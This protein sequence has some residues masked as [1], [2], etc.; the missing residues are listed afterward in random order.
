MVPVTAPAEG[1]APSAP[2]AE[3]AEDLPEEATLVLDAAP[4]RPSRKKKPTPQRYFVRQEELQL[5]QKTN[6][7]RF[8]KTTPT[9]I[10]GQDLDIPTFVRLGIKLKL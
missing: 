6:R 7:G 8:E 2:V 10:D 3:A 5:E 9:V 4:P 1:F